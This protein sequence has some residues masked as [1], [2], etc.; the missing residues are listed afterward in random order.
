MS[1][2]LGDSEI[3]IRSCRLVQLAP[4][5]IYWGPA[6]AE[7]IMAG[8]RVKGQGPEPGQVWSVHLAGLCW[9]T[10]IEVALKVEG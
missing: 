10:S 7:D 2:K 5:K 9:M 6:P 4:K 3:K 8:K 1:L